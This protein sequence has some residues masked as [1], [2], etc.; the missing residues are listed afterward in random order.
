MQLYPIVC[1][2]YWPN[3]PKGWSIGKLPLYTQKSNDKEAS[4]HSNTQEK[5][6]PHTTGSRLIVSVTV[7]HILVCSSKSFVVLFVFKLKCLLAAPVDLTLGNP[8]PC[9]LGLGSSS[10]FW[11]LT[12]KLQHPS[13]PSAFNI[14][15]PVYMIYLISY[16][17][18]ILQVWE[19]P[20]LN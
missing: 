19:P 2:K 1:L 11:S 17:I 6:V 16:P 7:G 10:D 12:S 5:P 4:K 15:P 18:S 14:L 3:T 9:I 8:R 13:C 20:T